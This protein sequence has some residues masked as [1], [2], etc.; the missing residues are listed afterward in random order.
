MRA[1]S[2]L[3]IRS[4]PLRLGQSTATERFLLLPVSC[5]RPRSDVAMSNRTTYSLRRGGG[6]G[7]LG[8]TSARTLANSLGLV[9]FSLPFECSS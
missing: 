3:T 1:P 4:R 5:C 8:A 2:W 6:G 9:R 7:G